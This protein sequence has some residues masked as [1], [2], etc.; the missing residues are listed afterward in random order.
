MQIKKTDLDPLLVFIKPP[1][2]IELENRLKGR[3]TETTDS[4]QRRL[5]VA[6]TE[7]EYGMIRYRS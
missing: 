5:S 2:I 1:S 7:I 6:R 3:K 4:L